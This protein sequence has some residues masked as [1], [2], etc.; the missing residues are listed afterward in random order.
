[1]KTLKTYILHL[2][3]ISTI[4]KLTAMHQDEEMSGYLFMNL[5][6]SLALSIKNRSNEMVKLDDF[7]STAPR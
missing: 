3:D 5:S 1:M 2:T 4:L 6:V 7:K